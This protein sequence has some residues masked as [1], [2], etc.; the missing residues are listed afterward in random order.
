M[1]RIVNHRTF[2]SK[3]VRGLVW[4]SS[5]SRRAASPAHFL[6]ARSKRPTAHIL[7]PNLFFSSVKALCLRFEHIDCCAL[8][9]P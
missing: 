3:P 5:L 2:P 8:Q 7:V 1:I 9:T 4:D 6:V